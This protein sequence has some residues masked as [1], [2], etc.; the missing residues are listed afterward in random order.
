LEKAAGRKL[1]YGSLVTYGDIE[2][3]K[4]LK[5][6]DPYLSFHYMEQIEELDDKT[7]VPLFRET[8]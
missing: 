7:S 1:S 4:A 3:L 6:R 5:N 2:V 8:R